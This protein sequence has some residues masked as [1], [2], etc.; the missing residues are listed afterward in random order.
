MENCETTLEYRQPSHSDPENLFP[1][2]TIL[3]LMRKSGIKDMSI[4]DE[5]LFEV[6]KHATS[7][8]SFITSEANEKCTREKRK[9]LGGDDIV[10]A[11]DSMGFDE[12]AKVIRSLNYKLRQVKR[13]TSAR[14]N[15][16]KELENI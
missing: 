2:T 3:R 14:D 15:E 12:Y 4:S 1:K 11:F 8:I 13:T 10:H 5:A 9:T 16:F 6:Q 7:F